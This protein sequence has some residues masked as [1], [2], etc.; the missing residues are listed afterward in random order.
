[1][2]IKHFIWKNVT[3]NVKNYYLYVFALMMSVALYFSFVTLQ[4]DP[5]LNDVEGSIKGSAA[6]KASSVLLIAII[7]T[8]LLYA[9]LIF[10]KRR[11]NEIGLLHLIGLTK[12]KIFRIL[13]AENMILYFGSFFAGVFIGFSIS[14]FIAMI[15][16]KIMGIDAVAKLQFSSQAFTQTAIVFFF[17]YL[18]IMIMNFV[19][20]KRQTILS[21]FQIKSNVE[22]RVKKPSFFQWMIGVLGLTLI[23]VGYYVSSKLF[24]GDFTTI[25]ELYMA[26][27][28]ILGS[29]IIGTYL[30]YKGS[31]T[32]IFNL[33]RKKK[34]G[35][36]SIKEVLSI[37]PIMFRMK[38]NAFLLT[39]ITTVSA[40][41][42]GLM[43]LSYISYYSIGI[44]AEENLSDDFGFVTSEDFETF[45]KVLDDQ[46]IPYNEKKIEGKKVE[47]NIEQISESTLKELNIDLENY[48]IVVISDESLSDLDVSDNEMVFSNYSSILRNV[49]SFKSS[50]VVEI[51]GSTY[52]LIGNY[53]D[54]ILPYYL[55]SGGNPTA[56]VDDGKWQQIDGTTVL[57]YGINIKNKRDLKKANDLFQ[58]INFEGEKP[59]SRLQ[60]I[61][62]Q[63]QMSG[64]M[65]FIVGFLGLTFLIVSGSILYF[66]QMDESEDGKEDY[67]ILRKLGFTKQ[68]LLSGI[69][70]KQLFNFGIPLIV[71]LLHSYFA[72]KSGW[73]LFGTE[74]WTP[75]IAV[76]IFYTALYSIFG[77]L[78]VSHY[79]QVI[80]R[81]L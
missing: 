40:L 44:S 80:K 7:V 68:D 59:H 65:M 50:G 45:Q 78:S 75:M 15:L 66:K 57:Y 48:P 34:N 39:V 70:I 81:A 69:R 62:E 79:K 72:V 61:I 41:A 49:F 73:F 28:F 55:R 22:E 43:S 31:I 11:G 56:I 71:G 67:T 25:N 10:I 18:F 76:M 52:E 6:I 35:Y 64:L 51:N 58:N 63:K 9:N 29:V 19:F 26:M 17:T 42:I 46:K 47:M 30:F 5:A 53:E 77:I 13:T 14:K 8:F 20:V 37:S 36:L 3:K 27:L 54:S 38:S 12:N 32:I 60:Y 16:F 1:M 21:L 2:G 4:Y 33:I 23:I 24:D 74:M